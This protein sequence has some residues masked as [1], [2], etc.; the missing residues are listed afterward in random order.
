MDLMEAQELIK[1][2]IGLRVKQESDGILIYGNAWILIVDTYKW[3]KLKLNN[4]ICL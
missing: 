2:K 3:I 1:G 4:F